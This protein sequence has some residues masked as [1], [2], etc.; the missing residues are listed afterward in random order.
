MAGLSWQ[1]ADEGIEDHPFFAGLKET[2]VALA[3]GRERASGSERLGM[4][5]DDSA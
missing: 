5:R 2:K 4:T 3:R 1:D